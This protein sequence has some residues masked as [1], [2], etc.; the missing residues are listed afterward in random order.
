MSV[1]RAYEVIKFQ[2]SGSALSAVVARDLDDP[3]VWTVI[4]CFPN[5]MRG[6]EQARSYIQEVTMRQEAVR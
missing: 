2:L 4:Q 6:L 1:A 5:T 3:S